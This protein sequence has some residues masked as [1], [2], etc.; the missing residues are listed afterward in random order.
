[1]TYTFPKGAVDARPNRGPARRWCAMHVD[2]RIIVGIW[3]AMAAL[4]AVALVYFRFSPAGGPTKR[5]VFRWY[6]VIGG[7]LVSLWFALLLG[8]P[9]LILAAG[10][11]PIAAWHSLRVTRFCDECGATQ[12]NQFSRPRFC[13]QC[14]DDLDAQDQSRTAPA[15]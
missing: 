10:I 13:A 4:I 5:R 8:L 9:G 3:V 12:F 2:S 11:F 15:L 7:C 1:M 6:T 14:G